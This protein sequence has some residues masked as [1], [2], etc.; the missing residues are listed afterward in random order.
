MLETDIIG[1]KDKAHSAGI[2]VERLEADIIKLKI[3]IEEQMS[4]SL[5]QKEKILAMRHEQASME[6]DI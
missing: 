2:E 1:E 3:L 5:R 6:Q 4:V